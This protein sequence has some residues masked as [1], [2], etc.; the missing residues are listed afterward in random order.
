MIDISK[1]KFYNE[2]E[3]KEIIEDAIPYVFVDDGITEVIIKKKDISDYIIYINR[4]CGPTDLK[5][6]DPQ[7][8]YQTIITT[9]GEFLDKSDLEI[10]KEII[11]RLVKIQTNQEKYKKIKTIDED[12]WEKVKNEIENDEEMEE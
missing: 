7:K 5:I 8:D 2:K 4:N 1:I 6:I 11:E 3:V 10:R 9:F 12:M